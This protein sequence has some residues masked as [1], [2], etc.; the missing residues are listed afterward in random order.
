MA[1]EEQK[2]KQNDA[3]KEQEKPTSKEKSDNKKQKEPSYTYVNSK[4]DQKD[5]QT[6]ASRKAVKTAA[7]G[8][9]TYLGG[10]VGAKAV[11]LAAKTKAGQQLINKGGDLLNKMPGMGKAAKK[12]DDNGEIDNIEKMI[13]SVSNIPN[14]KQNEPNETENSNNKGNM[15]N[16]SKYHNNESN[17]DDQEQEMKFSGYGLGSLPVKIA[18]ALIAPLLGLILLFTLIISIITL[19]FDEYGVALGAASEAGEETNDTA[20]E[21]TSKDE[22]EFFEILSSIKQEFQMQG[23]SIDTLK[24]VA[25]YYV[26]STN[27]KNV[28]YKTMTEGKI[29]EIVNAMFDGNTYSEEAFKQ[30]LKNNILSEYIKNLTEEKKDQLVNEVFNYINNFHDYIGKTNS[31]TCAATGTCIYE[32]EGFA[33]GNSNITKQ[34]TITNLQVRLMECGGSYGNGSDTKPIDQDL[35]PFEDYVAGVAYAEIGPNAADEAIKAQLIAARSY[36]LARP[37]SMG[38]ANGKKLEEENGQWILQI[39]SCVSDQVFCNIN[40]GCSYMGGG[41]GQGGFVR[42]GHISGAQRYR[43]PLPENHKLRTLAAE[44]QGEVVVNN[45]GYVINT[46]FLSTDQNRWQQ[47]ANQGLNYKQILL[48]TYNSSSRNYGASDIKKMNCSN[49]NS[50]NCATSS[51]TPYSNWKQYEGSWV[52]VKLGNSGKTIKEIGCLTT[53]IAMLIKKSGVNTNIKGTFD[54]GTFVEYLNQ[55]NG[56]ATG[57]NLLWDSVTTAAPGFVYKEQISLDGLSQQEKLTRIKNLL[58]QGS[59][60]VAEV[61]GKTG[62][63]WVA[64]DSVSGNKINMMDPG[65]TNTDL[66]N[67]YNWKNTSKIAYFVKNGA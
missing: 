37:I 5:S 14:Q 31:T 59:Y 47:L 56:F 7:K 34:M 66:W 9:A 61:K 45:Q 29:K 40:E 18:I 26:L 67:E 46:G 43:D 36:A 62:Q 39:A 42:S 27:N 58:D 17:Q 52:N 32:I 10:P 44:V 20:Y 19:D 55:N 13:N 50:S 41:D 63:H 25:V 12:L 4:K 28:T 3:K 16:S 1:E 33:I 6:D 8:A 22:K 11:D 49:G 53:S 51:N 24:I 65:S 38:N 35:V 15:K 2:P 57:G 54:P 21:P 48:Q 23:K 64:I 30:N 60:V